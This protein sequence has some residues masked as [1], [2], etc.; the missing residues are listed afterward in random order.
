[1]ES[2]DSLTSLFSGINFQ[3]DEGSG[4]TALSPPPNRRIGPPD[5]DRTTLDEPF[6]THVDT[7]RR[8]E[9][10][11]RP[12]LLCRVIETV[13]PETV[14]R[15]LQV[16]IL[17]V[18]MDETTNVDHH[19]PSMEVH[20]MSDV[21]TRCNILLPGRNN[22]NSEDPVVIHSKYKYEVIDDDGSRLLR[23]VFFADPLRITHEGHYLL[24][25]IVRDF[26]GHTL[27]KVSF[28]RQR[29]CHTRV[30]KIH[31]LGD[32]VSG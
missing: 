10:Q 23:F 25:Y 24:T 14:G 26:E 29:F 18:E 30:P 16:P 17:C 2:M 20:L 28:G 9:P 6:L 15:K 19:P 3:H 21:D 13:A 22:T 8:T 7:G 1:M 11:N 31:T 12:L 27:A 4:I 5:E 32:G